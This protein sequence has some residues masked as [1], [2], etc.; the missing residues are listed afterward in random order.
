M[1]VWGR[2][3]VFSIKV[4]I[5][6]VDFNVISV[7]FD[8]TWQWSTP[9]TL[10]FWNMDSSQYI[11][12]NV[13]LI[14]DHN[15]ELNKKLFS[16]ITTCCSDAFIFSC[17]SWWPTWQEHQGLS[18]LP[19]SPSHVVFPRRL[20]ACVHCSSTVQV[21]FEIACGIPRMPKTS[22]TFCF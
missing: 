15:F 16:K 12:C 3:C 13:K 6:D 11:N 21:F 22:C 5:I 18:C 7:L 10:C 17:R 4:Y 20:N 19:S 2:S 8:S 1:L 14:S 9:A